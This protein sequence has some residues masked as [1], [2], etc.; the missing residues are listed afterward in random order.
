MRDAPSYGIYFVVYEALCRSVSVNSTHHMGLR[1]LVLL[2]FAGGAA[3]VVAWASI[4]PIDV[5]KS[6]YQ[7]LP[8]GDRSSYLD[9]ARNLFRAGGW[10]VFTRGLSATLIRAFPLNAATFSVYEFALHHLERSL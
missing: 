3:G 6:C 8:L 9:C 5:V 4:Y 10:R 7:A 1:E 2:N